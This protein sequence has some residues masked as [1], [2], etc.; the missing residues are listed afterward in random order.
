MPKRGS[1]L[2]FFIIFILTFQLNAKQYDSWMADPMDTQL[3]TESLDDQ[4][5]YGRLFIPVMTKME[6]EPT[7]KIYSEDKLLYDDKMLG[8]SIFLKPGKYT[9]LFG[10]SS[11]A[12]DHVQ[13]H[14]TINEQ[15]TTIIKPDW[16]GLLVN[17]INENLENIRFGY[18]LIHFSNRVSVGTMYSRDEN[19]Y[20][21]VMSTWIL[22]P[23]KY[24]LIKMGE[25]FNT[26]QNFTTFELKEG[27]LNKINIVISSLTNT[28]IGAGELKFL[29]DKKAIQKNWHNY[30][31]LKGS[32]NLNHNNTQNE[33]EPQTD[34]TF[35]GKVDN[36]F[37]YDKTPY[38]LRFT[39]YVEE[40]WTKPAGFDNLRI[41]S[42]EL[43]LV[44]T[45]IY[46]FTKVFGIYSEFVIDT[47]IFPKEYYSSELTINDTIVMI[48]NSGNISIATNKDA[49]KISESFTPLSLKEEL[50]FNFSLIKSSSSNLYIRTGI[51][52]FQNLND[53]VYTYNSPNITTDTFI[54]NELVSKY[55]TGLTFSAGLDIRF[56]NNVTYYSKA[57]FTYYLSDDKNYDLEW[58]NN[59]VFKLFKYV[60]IDYNL[61][62][63]YNYAKGSD[64]NYLKYDNKFALEF[65]YYLNN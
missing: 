32:F 25:P 2:I 39:Q 49:Q 7:I 43:S 22:P 11:E 37:I 10:S 23:G 51:G 63:R 12:E 61:N 35:T 59:I 34:L 13:K 14:F 36:K 53:N 19:D 58:D 41:S 27:E 16:S 31:Y 30:L 8:E 21:K 56:L 46:Y 38:Y 5:G 62:L 9:L 18:E 26:V 28:F 15:Q 20:E 42:D 4:L 54:F 47:E 52:L 24:K 65:S 1:I 57:D 44:N 64:K 48:D 50:G 40:Q 45:A 29:E 3:R 55:K 6:W 33:L 60:S 17:V